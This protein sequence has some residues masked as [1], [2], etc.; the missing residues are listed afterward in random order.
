MEITY[1]K[2]GKIFLPDFEEDYSQPE[3][4]IGKFGKLRERFLYEE[5]PAKYSL[6]N[7]EGTL[8][9]HLL[10]IDRDSEAML[11]TLM[12]KKKAKM[13]LTE[14]MKQQKPMEWAQEMR[15]IQMEAEQ[16]VI[17]ELIEI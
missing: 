8:K 1:R 16:T 10:D 2:A 14:E 6:M 11:T 3:G 17:R 13:N 9:Q 12:Q 5:K 4:E 15:L 7:I